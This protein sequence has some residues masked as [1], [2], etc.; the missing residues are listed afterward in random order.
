VVQTGEFG[1]EM[2]VTLTNEGPV[3][4][5]LQVSPTDRNLDL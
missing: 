2:Q 3:T 5:W 1:A 4:F